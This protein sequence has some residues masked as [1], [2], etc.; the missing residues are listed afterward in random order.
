MQYIARDCEAAKD[1]TMA[2]E[3]WELAL[4]YLR[5]QSARQL[6]SASAAQFYTA[7]GKAYAQ[8][9]DDAKA[10]DC[11]LRGLSIIPRSD[12]NYKTVLQAALDHALKGKSLVQAVA[13]HENNV[14][15]DGS[16]KPHLRI[17]FAE[18]FKKENKP[19]DMLAQLRIAADLLPKDM[20]LRKEVID[21]YKQLKDTDAAIDEYRRWS[22]LDPQNIE[23]YRGWGDLYESM[24]RRGDAILAWATM[25]EVR[26]REAEGYRAYGQKLAAIGEREKAASAFRQALKYRPTEYDIAKELAEEYRKLDAVAGNARIGKLWT[27]GESACRKAMEDVED[28]PAPWLNLG[29][30]LEAQRK[31]KEAREL[32][33]RIAVRAWPRF[34]NETVTEARKRLGEMK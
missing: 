19:R 7:C 13:A 8:N 31:V 2:V 25:A 3:V 9:G 21:G 27:D 33:E 10:L 23:L 32:Y 26:P 5:A 30:F 6:D 28:D 12:S 1:F 14:A 15:S 4:R 16:D 34:R 24:G 22:A 18:A 29:R 11:F 17:A 20:A